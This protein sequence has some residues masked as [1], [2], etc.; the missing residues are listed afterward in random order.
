MLASSSA[1]S[2]CS[3]VE[4]E[5]DFLEFLSSELEANTQDATLLLGRWLVEYRS[6]RAY[7]IHVLQPRTVQSQFSVE[8]SL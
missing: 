7:E 5:P 4:S 8:G 1:S 6:R 3:S 2:D